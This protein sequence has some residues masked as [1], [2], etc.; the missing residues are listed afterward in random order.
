VG[1]RKIH[2]VGA[3]AATSIALVITEARGAPAVAEFGV[4]ASPYP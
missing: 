2:R 1:H 3:R 4:Y